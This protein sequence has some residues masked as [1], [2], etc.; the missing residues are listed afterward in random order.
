MIRVLLADDSVAVRGMLRK[1]LEN[2]KN[3]EIVGT[4]VNGRQAV[5]DYQR[6]RPDITLLDVEMPEMNGLEALK[7]IL[8][9]DV[10]ARI[11]MCSSLTKVGAAT[12]LEALDIGALDYIPKPSSDGTGLSMTEFSHQLLQKIKALAPDTQ[13]NTENA[14]AP[15]AETPKP[16][17]NAPET[18]SLRPYPPLFSKAGLIAIGSST[19]G[20]QALFTLFEGLR[21]AH[22]KVP[23][24]VTQHMPPTFTRLLAEHITEK[25]GL[26]AFEAEEGMYL[27]DG[28]IYIAPG[29]WHMEIVRDAKGMKVHLSDAPQENYCRPAVDVMFRSLHTANIPNVLAIILTGMGSDGLEGSKLLMSRGNILVGQDEKTSVVWGMPAAVARAGLCSA[30]L[31]LEEIAANIRRY[32]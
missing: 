8:A 6:V 17:A 11:I 9:F 32:L 12:T 31:P 18:Y 2:E 23:I 15:T 1:I 7:A 28:C 29:N 19:G 10:K 20:P 16:A 25:T 4:A 27:Q 21:N 26:R 24:V 5:S 13:T 3:I 30:I 22:P 14:S